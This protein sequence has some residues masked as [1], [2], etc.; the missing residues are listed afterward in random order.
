VGTKYQLIVNWEDN[1]ALSYINLS[2]N[3][4]ILAEKYTSNV[5]DS[6]SIDIDIHTS[7]VK[8]T[9]TTK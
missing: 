2:Q 6:V 1:V 5:K 8:E 4:K 3:G 7:S 9:Y